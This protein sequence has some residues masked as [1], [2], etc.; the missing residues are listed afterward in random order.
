[1]SKYTE[2]I[3]DNS[4]WLT[5]TPSPVAM[6]LPFYIIEAGHF[7]AEREYTVERTEHDSYLMLYTING[8]G[9][10]ITGDTEMAIDKECA[11][12]IDCRKYHKYFSLCDSWEFFWIHFNGNAVKTFFDILYPN[13]EYTVKP[14]DTERFYKKVSHIISNIKSNDVAAGVAV[15]S[16]I[17]ELFNILISSAMELEQQSRRIEYEKDIDAAVRFIKNRYSDNITID[18]IID[19]LHISKFHFIRIFSR[20]MGVT[21]YSYLISYRINMSKI[22]L[23]TTLMPVAEIAEHCGFLDTSNFINHFKKRTGQRPLQYRKDFS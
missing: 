3:S 18:D 1:M 14:G 17:H 15:S 21:P 22:L 7:I 16:D 6:T 20:I 13:K 10:V 5:D 19:E 9:S 8:C 2:K 23:R 11:A 4:L 12:V